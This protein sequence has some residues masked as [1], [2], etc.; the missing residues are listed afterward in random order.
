MAAAAAV[1]SSAGLRSLRPPCYFV[2]SSSAKRRSQIQTAEGI[3]AM[4][5]LL[6]HGVVFGITGP[7]LPFSTQA[8]RAW[9]LI[10]TP[11]FEPVRELVPALAELVRSPG[12][13]VPSEVLNIAD[14]RERA[15][16]IQAW[17]QTSPD[18]PR[19]IEVHEQLTALGLQLV[20][21]DRVPLS[22]W[23]ITIAGL[24][25]GDLAFLPQMQVDFAEGG[26]GQ[27]P[28]FYMVVA[29]LEEP[30]LLRRAQVADASRPCDE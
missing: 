30:Q 10:P 28:P 13:G 18:A 19:R 4:W 24:P 2:P 3:P 9:P 25:P 29:S 20:G 22:A 5:K 7:E 6:S 21:E 27:G 23:S 8:V 26:F 1:H 17:I 12:E 11:A 16:A 14:E 15:R